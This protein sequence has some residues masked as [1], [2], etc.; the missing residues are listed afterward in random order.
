MAFSMVD[1]CMGG[2]VAAGVRADGEWMGE[3]GGLMGY[4]PMVH[5]TQCKK[6][7]LKCLKNGRVT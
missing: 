3:L 2:V 7:Q 4:H 5:G 1:V 6:F